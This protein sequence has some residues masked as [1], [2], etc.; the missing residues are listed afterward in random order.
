[1]SGFEFM[2]LSVL[3]E[4]AYYR[5][6]FRGYIPH[7]PETLHQAVVKIQSNFLS[8]LTGPMNSVL[9]PMHFKSLLIG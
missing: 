1:M 8:E 7:F 4:Y 5:I 2:S 9:K 3:N 6:E